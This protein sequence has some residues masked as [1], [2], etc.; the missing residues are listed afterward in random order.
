MI[1]HIVVGGP[2]ELIPP[3]QEFDEDGVVWVGV[4]RGVVYLL[5][6]GIMPK[7]AFGDFDSVTELELNWIRKNIP[8]LDIYPAQKD[9]TDME[10]ALSWAIQQK[11]EKIYLFGATG[12][13]MDHALANI[14]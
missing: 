7:R 9:E 4:D 13:R 14:Q 11:P 2:K 8:H 5:G 3:L 6:N 1:I 12:G 10:L